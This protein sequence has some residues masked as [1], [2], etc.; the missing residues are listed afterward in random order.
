MNP[1][2]SVVSILAG[3]FRNS[4][5]Q[6]ATSLGAIFQSHNDDPPACRVSLI[7][8][9]GNA[10]FWSADGKR[11][12]QADRCPGQPLPVAE[13][14]QE[15][16]GIM[17]AGGV[18]GGGT[19][20]G[21]VFHKTARWAPRGRNAPCIRR[22]PNPQTPPNGIGRAEDDRHHRMAQDPGRQC[23]HI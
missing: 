23:S 2:G 7:L 22:S 21:V 5:E 20:T 16:P 1:D 17:P 3:N 8:E 4:Y 11:A 10:G 14:R 19:P 6:S 18:Y 13:W 9:C 15:N 12:W